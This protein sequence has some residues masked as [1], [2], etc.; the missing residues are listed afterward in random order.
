MQACDQTAHP[1]TQNGKYLIY[2]RLGAAGHESGNQR[3]GRKQR[4]DE[5]SKAGD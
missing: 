1:T 2:S 3:E 5:N 4:D